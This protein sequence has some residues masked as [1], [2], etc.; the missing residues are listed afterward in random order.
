MLKVENLKKVFGRKVVVQIESLE[1]EKG[2]YWIRGENGSG[3]STFLKSLAG[4]FSFQGEISYKNY[5]LKKSPKDYLKYVSFS[6][7]EPIFPGFLTGTQLLQFFMH[8]KGDEY[9]NI[10]ELLLEFDMTNYMDHLPISS[11]SSGMLKK[12]SLVLAFVGKPEVLLL[13]EPYI[14]LD[15]KSIDVL[16]K[17]VIIQAGL[18]NTIIL[19]SHLDHLPFEVR[20]ILFKINP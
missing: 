15:Q 6:E 14:T 4:L 1:F 3:K 19:T 16:N 12:L 13:D 9:T 17:Q 20:E 10:E 11:Y 8:C 5:S 2:I 7:T 18:G